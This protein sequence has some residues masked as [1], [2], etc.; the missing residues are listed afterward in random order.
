MESGWFGGRQMTSQRC[1]LTAAQGGTP[2]FVT[3]KSKT[4]CS[5]GS[6]LTTVILYGVLEDIIK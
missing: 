4:L 2:D 3:R 6:G 5:Q 1:F